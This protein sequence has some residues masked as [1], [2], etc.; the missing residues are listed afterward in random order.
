VAKKARRKVASTKQ[1]PI[2]KRAIRQLQSVSKDFTGLTKEARALER[3]LASPNPNKAT[4]QRRVQAFAQA[5]ATYAQP[6]HATKKTKKLAVAKIAKRIT[7]K[8]LP[9]YKTAV[10]KCLGD[11]ETCC[12]NVD[13]RFCAALAALCITN[14]LK[15]LGTVGATAYTAF[16]IFGN[17]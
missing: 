1:K 8:T 13:W 16:K 17:H 2:N 3:A 9:S 7:A 12:R 6:V 5:A 10:F 15:A 4:T 14:Q 11:Y